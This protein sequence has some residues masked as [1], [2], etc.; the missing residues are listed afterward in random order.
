[1]HGVLSRRALL[2]QVG[3]SAVNLS[4]LRCNRSKSIRFSLLEELCRELR[5]QPGDLLVYEPAPR[6]EQD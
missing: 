1:M 6:E 2:H 3:R 5:C 4:H